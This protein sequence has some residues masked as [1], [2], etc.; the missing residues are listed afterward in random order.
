MVAVGGVSTA[1][2]RSLTGSSFVPIFQ[3]SIFDIVDRSKARA[4]LQAG[5]DE[6]LCATVVCGAALVSAGCVTL[7]SR[8]TE[9]GGA[10]APLTSCVSLFCEP[11]GEGSPSMFLERLSPLGMGS[12]DRFDEPQ[13]RGDAKRPS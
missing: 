7:F 10:K 5:G 3:D 4:S 8:R 1:G 12:I 2:W 13:R 6:A 11:A 9:S